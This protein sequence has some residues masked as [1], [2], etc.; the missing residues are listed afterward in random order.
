MS[1]LSYIH[2]FKM[3]ILHILHLAYPKA[4]RLLPNYI[5]VQFNKWLGSPSVI[6]LQGMASPV[7]KGMLK[8][9]KKSGWN[10][11]ISIRGVPPDAVR[12][13]VRYLYSCR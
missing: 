11:S 5:I 3:K 6:L 4:G 1:D 12:V 10:R 8:Q 13:F 7:I 9:S 2:F